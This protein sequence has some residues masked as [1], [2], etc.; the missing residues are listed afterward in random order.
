M[1]TV[2]LG[3]TLHEVLDP[4]FLE[5]K[6]IISSV[7]SSAEFTHSMVSFKQSHTQV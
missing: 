1:Q 3:D 7:L 4:I 2:S 5:K 6:R